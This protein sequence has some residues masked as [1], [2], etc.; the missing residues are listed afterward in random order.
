MK[1]IPFPYLRPLHSVDCV[2]VYYT[3]SVKIRLRHK[4]R[5][6]LA[7]IVT[8]RHYQ[9]ASKTDQSLKR[10]E[11]CEK[12]LLNIEI[13]PKCKIFL[14]LVFHYQTPKNSSRRQRQ[15]NYVNNL[16]IPY[17]NR[18]KDTAKIISSTKTIPEFVSSTVYICCL[19]AVLAI[20]TYWVYR[21]GGTG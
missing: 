9:N 10:G 14:F 6:P 7:F 16:L 3:G 18:K 21:K 20:Q 1:V 17:D 8:W 4:H 12:W 13:I 15:K 11:I 5:T 19:G 2:H